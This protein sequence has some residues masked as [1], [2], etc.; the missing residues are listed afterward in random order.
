MP[1]NEARRLL[2]AYNTV[3]ELNIPEETIENALT[4]CISKTG[5]VI[6]DDLLKILSKTSQ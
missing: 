6:I 2:A 3:Y 1:I 4:M 5:N